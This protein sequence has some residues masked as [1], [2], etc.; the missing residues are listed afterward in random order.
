MVPRKPGRLVLWPIAAPILWI[1]GLCPAHPVYMDHVEHAARVIVG[2]DNIDIR[3]RLTFHEFRSLAERRSMDADGDEVLGPTERQAYLKRILGGL[4]DRIEL[5]VDGRRL[6]VLD[7]YPPRLDLMGVQAVSLT[8]HVLELSF[9]ARTPAHLGPDSWLVM[10]DR[11]WPDAPALRIGVAEGVHGIRLNRFETIPPADGTGGDQ[12]RLEIRAVVA[13][14]PA[15][16]RTDAGPPEPAC[17]AATGVTGP[18]AAA[19]AAVVAVVAAASL[20]ELRR[21]RR[22]RA[23]QQSGV[24]PDHRTEDLP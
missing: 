5:E 18:Q 20:D 14:V 1:C 4:A 15:G 13:E 12:P 23:V 6:P 9:F 17:R 8:H 2:P 22:G 3:L 24:L 7:L 11:L 16:R 10:R 21:R 19:A